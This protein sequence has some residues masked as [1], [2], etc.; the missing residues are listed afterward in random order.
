[1]AL[2]RMLLTPP[3]TPSFAQYCQ[4]I[5]WDALDDAC[6]QAK[7]L[8]DAAAN[9]LKPKVLLREC[10][11]DTYDVESGLASVIIEGIRFTGKALT[12]LA[13]IH[14][15][16]P[17]IATCGDGMEDFRLER[18]DMLAP[19]W[20]DMLKA[21]ALG[22]ARQTMRLYCKE[23]F[24]WSKPFSLN[25]GSGNTDIWPIEQLGGLFTLL[26]EA[27]GTRGS[28]GPGDSGVYLTQ[29]SLMVPNKTIAGLLFTSKD[30]DY[31]SCAYCERT[32]CPD[33]RVP[34][35]QKL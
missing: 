6:T 25:P 31:E 5:R 10:F 7:Q 11:I 13:G 30:S 17:Y 14:R 28:G 34:F 27:G 19:Y 22:C 18:Y 4:S 21:Q 33:R 2:G 26:G 15:V 16:L 9:Q 24:G 20:L 12:A 23:A 8:F 3:F 32:G 35:R 1:M 29:S